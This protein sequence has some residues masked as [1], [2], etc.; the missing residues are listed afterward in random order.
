MDSTGLNH[1]V[2]ARDA[3]EPNSAASSSSRGSQPIDRILAVSGVDKALETTA[4]P[5]T[6]DH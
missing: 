2:R 5:A 3:R 1:L 4:E 6:L